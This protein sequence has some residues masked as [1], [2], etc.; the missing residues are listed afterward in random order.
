MPDTLLALAAAIFPLVA[1]GTV[2]FV[3]R[4]VPRRPGKPNILFGHIEILAIGLFVLVFLGTGFI[5][6]GFSSAIQL[7]ALIL[8]ASTL[9]CLLAAWILWR[10]PAS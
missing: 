2:L 1:V 8:A 9:S 10:K 6:G 4:R 3:A 5:L 7:P